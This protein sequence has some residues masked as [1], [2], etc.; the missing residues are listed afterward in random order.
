MKSLVSSVAHWVVPRRRDEKIYISVSPRRRGGSQEVDGLGSSLPPRP[1]GKS[2]REEEDSSHQRL[3]KPNTI[4]AALATG[5]VRLVRASW[6]VKHANSGGFLCRRQELPEEAF[7]G[8]EELKAIFTQT[9]R[10]LG[11][12][13]PDGA[14]PIIVV[15][16]PW[17][18]PLHPECARI[19]S[20]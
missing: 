11:R 14:L 16:A 19:M 20:A 8:V 1:L 4:W 7:V 15:S 17:L 10:P 12:G 18:T 2:E 3:I 6:I 9:K 13:N 5:D